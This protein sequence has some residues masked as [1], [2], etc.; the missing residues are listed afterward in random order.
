MGR[1]RGCAHEEREKKREVPRVRNARTQARTYARV[2]LA[3]LH[4]CLPEELLNMLV[5]DFM[6]SRIFWSDDDMTKGV[7]L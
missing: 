4:T 2:P 3:Q 1:E 5:L 7:V 6:L